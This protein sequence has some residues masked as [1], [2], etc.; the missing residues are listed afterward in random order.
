M[1][2]FVTYYHIYNYAI[3]AAG[4][5]FQEEKNHDLFPKKYHQHIDP[6]ADKMAWC[7]ME[8]Y[9]HLLVRIKELEALRLIDRPGFKNP[10]DDLDE[11]SASN[12]LSHQF[13]NFF[14]SYTQAF[15]KVYKCRGSLFIKNFKRKKIGIEAYLLKCILHVHLN[16]VK[17]GFVSETDDWKHSSFRQFPGLKPQLLA[18]LFGSEKNYFEIHQDRKTTL[19]TIGV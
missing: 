3:G 14:S 12:L 1:L 9:F 17:H 2:C 8:S 16:P 13:S 15:N 7:L 18:C 5:L 6:I 11:K 19:M 10:E 4:K